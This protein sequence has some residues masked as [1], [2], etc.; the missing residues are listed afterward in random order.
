MG[1]KKTEQVI[2]PVTVLKNALEFDR[3]ISRLDVHRV[4][5]EK[6]YQYVMSELISEDIIAQL[7]AFHEKDS[8]ASIAGF[9][10]KNL[11]IIS[12]G[13]LVVLRERLEK[14]ELHQADKEKI[15]LRFL[16]IG[17]Q[18]AREKYMPLVMLLVVIL[19]SLVIYIVSKD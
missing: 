9:V 11:F 16:E 12:P 1:R 17:R 4:D 19:I 6:I 5:K 13:N 15:T 7:N 18:N 2:T 14:L 3:N 8:N 10:L